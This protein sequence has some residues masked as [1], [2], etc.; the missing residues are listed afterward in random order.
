MYYAKPKGKQEGSIDL[1]DV[2][3]CDFVNHSRHFH[4]TLTKKFYSLEAATETNAQ[5]W[6]NSI[7]RFLE[8]QTSTHQGISK[9]QQVLFQFSPSSQ[10]QSSSYKGDLVLVEID[11]DGSWQLA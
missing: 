3:S 10:Q 4:I 2:I 5:T 7:K 6:V 1:L 8:K 9:P 11:R